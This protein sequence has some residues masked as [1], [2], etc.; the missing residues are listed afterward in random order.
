MGC[1]NPVV[2]TSEL[3]RETSFKIGIHTTKTMTFSTEVIN[4]NK[5]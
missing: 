1:N 2:L 5:I 3:L 4:T